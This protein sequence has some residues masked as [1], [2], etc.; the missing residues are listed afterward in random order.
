[1]S[2]LAEARPPHGRGGLS[3]AELPLPEIGRLAP[4][5]TRLAS[6][7]PS[8]EKTIPARAAE[9]PTVPPSEVGGKPVTAAVTAGRIPVRPSS[10]LVSASYYLQLGA[11]GESSVAVALAD[12]LS[13]DYPVSVYAFKQ[14]K[15]SLY[16]VMIGPLNSDESGTLLYLFTAQGYKGAFVRK[17]E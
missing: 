10:A 7:R 15:K 11:Y 1:M 16:K 8:A 12:N 14:N 5:V 13:P 2:T 3:A 17:G 9:V 4:E 6:G